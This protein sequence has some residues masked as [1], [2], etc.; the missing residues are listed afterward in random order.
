MP[1]T[2]LIAESIA[3]RFSSAPTFE[4]AQLEAGAIN[5]TYLVTTTEQDGSQHKFVLQH[6]SNIFPTYIMDN[7]EKVTDVVG[8]DVKIPSLV[9]TESGDLFLTSKEDRWWRALEYIAGETINESLSPKR[10][11]SA[12]RL[13]GS[14]HNVLADTA[15]EIKDPLPHFHDT[16]YYIDR[17]KT[18]SKNAHLEE[19]LT[20]L[21]PLIDITLQQYE[22]ISTNFDT[23]PKRIIHAD[24]KLN[25]VM[26]NGTEATA[27]IDMD[28]LMRHNIAVELG[29][30][31]RS[32]CGIT[33]EDNV[34]QIFDVTIANEALAGYLETATFLTNEERDSILD[35][36]ALITIELAARF[37]T[38]AF[39]EKY[40][41]LQPTYPDLY[42]QNKT[43]AANQLSLLEKFLE[44]KN[45]I[46]I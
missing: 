4:L 45:K 20:E 14:F 26:F 42:I 30:A 31:L 29:D 28:T 41:R 11:R 23:L 9:K 27:L 19:K 38:D 34:K 8:N 2:L 35:G 40:F 15:I 44:T 39:E 17:L 22:N 32:W 1:H 3:A 37:I 16:A 43:K 12:G 21:Q 13:V 33:G 5:E 24:L 7:L 36:I 18:V 10:A 46:S 6:M 25:N